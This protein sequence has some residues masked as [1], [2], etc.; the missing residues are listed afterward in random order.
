MED[1]EYGAL[2]L[3]FVHYSTTPLFQYFNPLLTYISVD[4]FKSHAVAFRE[5]V[6][7]R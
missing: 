6:F 4:T 1:L 2:E 5:P 3:R 7:S